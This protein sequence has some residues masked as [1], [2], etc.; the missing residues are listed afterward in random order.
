[1]YAT[2]PAAWVSKELVEQTGPLLI[3][4]SNLAQTDLPPESL[5]VMVPSV[6]KPQIPP[7][8]V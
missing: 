3:H 7:A 1:M 8:H 5:S 4:C 2:M 6:N